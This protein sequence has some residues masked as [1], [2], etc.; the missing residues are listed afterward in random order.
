MT[1]ET[2]SMRTTYS[3]FKIDVTL[4]IITGVLAGCGLVYEYLLSHY[5]ARVLGAVETVIFTIISLMIVSMGVGSFL[6]GLVRNPF[7]G[8]VVLELFLAF[9]GS[10][11]VLICSGIM[12]GTFILPQVI[13]ETLGF[14]TG[15]PLS[16]GV[17]AALNDFAGMIPYIMACI[18]GTLI[19]MEIPLI[20]RI[21]EILHAEHI[22]NNIGT[23]YGADYI[24]AG[25]GALI[26]VGWMLSIDP[27]LAGALTAMANLLVGFVFICKFYVRIKYRELMLTLHGLLFVFALI[28]VF[29]GPSWQAMAEDIM[30]ADRVVYNR[31]TKFQRLVVTRR[32]N[33]PSGKPLFT[34]HINGHVQFASQDEEIYHSMLVFPA[35]MASARRDN[36][37]IVGGGD[38]LALRD[39]LSW[40]P[41]KVTLLDLDEK[42]IE[43]FKTVN[44]NGDNKLFIEM[45]KQS[46]SD[47]RVDVIVGD[48]WLSVDK[49]IA[50]GKRYDS[51]I[52]DLPDPN[53]PDLNKLYST[54][55]YS[56]LRNVLAGDGAMVVQSTSPYHAK[57]T[58]LSIGKTI[59]ASGFNNVDQ[60]HTNVPSFGEWGWTI[61]TPHGASGKLRIADFDG[62]MPEAWA[63]PPMINASFVFGRNF[64]ADKA[65]IKVNKP[66]SGVVYNYHLKDWGEVK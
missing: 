45:N 10:A 61:A 55:F 30:Y 64:F 42:L 46:L 29:Q 22:K 16:G 38:G 5:A 8:F 39:V 62:D 56:K 58:F 27:A 11:A 50:T 26:W 43:F 59:E 1:I 3:R 15:L 14:P 52:V 40:A 4:I 19:G 18:L 51:I 36:I 2:A 48:A 23:I 25:I 24:G 35:M 66:R 60:Y 21:R 47:P 49:L 44:P 53:H 63:T 41:K 54:G 32:E 6:S 13:S 37:L 34:F 28:V 65:S 7:L 12:A 20:A 9:F 17:F 31:D 57:R 33:G